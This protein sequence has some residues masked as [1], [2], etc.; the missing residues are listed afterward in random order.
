MINTE[1]ISSDFDIELQLG[2]GWFETALTVL[3]DHDL[4]L[5]GTPVAINSV[6][7][8]FEDDWDLLIDATI[9]IFTVTLRAAVAL[10][11]DGSELTITTDNPLVPPR[12]IP[13]GALKGLPVP[14]VLVKLA[15]DADHEDVLAVLANVDI[16]AVAQSEE[17]RDPDDFFE[18]GDA[19]SA[20]SFLPKGEHIAFGMGK[21]TYA[22]FANNIWHTQLR[23][24]DGT[25]PLPDADNKVGDWSRVSMTAEGGRLKLT[26]EGDVPVDS[27][28]ID[29]IPDPHVTVTIWLKPQ[30]NDEG[31]LAFELE[32]ETSIDTGILGDLFAGIV[33]GLIGLIIGLFTGGWGILIGFAIGAAAGVI[34]LEVAEAVAGFV[35]NGIIKA[36]INGQAVGEIRCCDGGIVQVATPNPDSDSFNLSVLNTIPTSIP[37]N[38]DRPDELYQRTL[39]VSSVYDTLKANATGFGAAG[40]SKGVEAFQPLPAEITNVTYSQG[41]L[42]SL[43]YS[44]D[45]GQVK[46]LTAQEVFERAG[47]IELAAPFKVFSE[48]D[49]VTLRIPA[50]QLATICLHPKRIHREETIIKEIEFENGLH[51][52]VPDAIALQDAAASVVVGYQLI[53]PRDYH[54]YYRAK[55]DFFL[56]NNLENLERY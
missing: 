48:P 36:K 22:R 15:G 40:L 44:T 10:N 9:G 47:Q 17:P 35:V 5:P 26:L 50:G 19:D 31:G 27:P 37:I 49:D 8:I 4:L 55:A 25:H 13:F 16:Q 32:T 12:T 54:A 14:P 3:A 34:V 29:L 52:K 56:D 6:T 2:G 21:S 38:V 24:D 46:V 53:H 51:L 43:E 7:V 1:R 45:D 23:A 30:I 18:R 42:E 39:L 33:G 20:Q 41:V 28:I 11:E